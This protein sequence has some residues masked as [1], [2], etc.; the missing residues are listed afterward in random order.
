V[1]DPGTLTDTT[2]VGTL[3]ALSLFKQVRN[4]GSGAC[5][6]A[7]A[8]NVSGTPGNVLE[9]CIS[10][11]NLSTQTLTQVVVSDPVPFFTTYIPGSLSLG[12]TALSDAA[13]ADAGQVVSGVVRVQV[14]TLGPGGSGQLCYRVQIR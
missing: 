9:Y 5:S 4:C 8:T 1:T 10:Y 14:G 13:D 7:Y 2:T 11:R 12:G 3:G 6:G